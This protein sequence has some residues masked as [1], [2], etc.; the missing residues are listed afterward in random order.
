M[1]IVWY[2]GNSVKQTKQKNANK[3]VRNTEKQK[4]AKWEQKLSLT[5]LINWK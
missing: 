5:F 4:L 3:S 2:I 1:N